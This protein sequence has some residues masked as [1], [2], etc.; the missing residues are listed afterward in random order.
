M[1]FFLIILDVLINNYSNFTSFFFL[2]YLYN[3][4]YKYYVLTALILDLVIFNHPFYNLIFLSAIYLLNKVF[5]DLNKNNILNF[6]F[7]NTFNLIVY[8]ILSNLSSYF[9]I[10]VILINIGN[11]LFINLLFYMLSYN[12]YNKGNMLE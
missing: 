5:T 2:I 7:I 10:P 3:K 9:S 4:P 12:C 11:S 8:I 6:I 1:I